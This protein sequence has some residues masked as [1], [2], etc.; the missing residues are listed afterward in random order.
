MNSQQE[1]NRV[2]DQSAQAQAQ[3]NADLLSQRQRAH[4]AEQEALRARPASEAQAALA[5]A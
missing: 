4:G 1:V 2:Q 3:A 5:Q